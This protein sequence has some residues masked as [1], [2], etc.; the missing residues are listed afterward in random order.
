MREYELAPKGNEIRKPVGLWEEEVFKDEDK[1]P[2]INQATLWL[3][4]IDDLFIIWKGS[5]DEAIRYID[6][7]NDNDRN[8]RL[9]YN[10]SRSSIDFLDP[11]IKIK[12][13]MISTELFRK[14]TAGNSLLHATSGHPDGPKWSIP[15][16]E[17]LRAKRISNTDEAFELEQKDMVLRFKQRGY[18]DWVIKKA[19]EKI[20]KVE[21]VQTLFDNTVKVENKNNEDIRLILTYNED[22]TQIKKIISK[23]CNILKCDPIIANGPEVSWD[24]EFLSETASSG[25]TLL[26]TPYRNENKLL[27]NTLKQSFG[28]RDKSLVQDVSFWNLVVPLILGIDRVISVNWCLADVDGENLEDGGL[29]VDGGLV[30]KDEEACLDADES[31]VAADREGLLNVKQQ[32]PLTESFAPMLDGVWLL[33]METVASTSGCSRW[34]FFSQCQTVPG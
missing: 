21:R 32:L 7:L 5:E 31:L 20:R 3:R 10:I 14:T 27:T 25:E 9:T 29:K 26:E 6:K 15:Y 11:R 17:L 19:M 12:D 22:T 4:Y 23:H 8:I 18:P 33:S 34:G 24:V 16:G 30:V 13:K 28:K 1:Y 2:E